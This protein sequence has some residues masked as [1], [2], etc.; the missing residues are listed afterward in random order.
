MSYV[1]LRMNPIVAQA[2]AMTVNT[3]LV[4]ALRE[5]IHMGVTDCL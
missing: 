1:E 4:I 3:N 5:L 2:L